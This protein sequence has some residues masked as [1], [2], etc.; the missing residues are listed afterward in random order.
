MRT[1]LITLCM[2][3][4]LFSCLTIMGQNEQFWSSGTVVDK[5]NEPLPG[6]TVNVKG[7]GQGVVTDIDGKYRIRIPN[8]NSI[9]VFSFVG[10]QTQEVNVNNRTTINVVLQEAVTELEE[11]VVVG[12]GQQKKE[13]VVAALSTISATA[14]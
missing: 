8:R 13:S 7:G 14:L 11:M 2:L 4:M 3:T 9:L 10:F 1:K 5:Q 12:Y 6:V